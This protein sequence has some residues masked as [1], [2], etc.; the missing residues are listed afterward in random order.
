MKKIYKMSLLA[1]M[2]IL[3]IGCDREDF[4][5][6]NTNPSDV[7]E[8]DI[9]FLVAK[10]VELMYNNDYTVWFYNNFDYV[11]PW[12]Q[13]TG[14]G[15]GNGEEVVEMGPFGNQSLYPALMANARDVQFKVDEMEDRASMQAMRAMTIPSVIHT[16]LSV[17][18][19]MGY[20]P[21]TEAGLAAYTTPALLRPVY[22]SQETLFNT[23]L[24]EL[25][26]A[27][28]AFTSSDQTDI[29]EQ[30]VVF[31]GDYAKW[32]KF[33]NLLKLRIA[34]RLINKDR[35]KALQIAEQVANSSVGYMD[36]LA[37]DFIY[38]RDIN[39]FG[40][41]NGTQPGVGGK[42]L[43][44][45][46]VANKDPRV[47]FLFDK[48]DF[49]GEVVQTF[50]DNG[51]ALPAYVE[52]YV[53]YDVDGNFAGWTGPGEPW[54]RYFGAPLSPDKRF[55]SAY[56]EYFR[57]GEL[58]RITLSVDGN[59]YEKT[60]SSTSSYLEKNVRT[61]INYIYPTTVGPDARYIDQGVE[62]PPLNV[63]LGSSAE[64]NLYL[65]E[66]KLLGA[67]VPGDAQQYFNRGV[68]LSVQRMDALAANN[69]HPYYE[70]DPVYEDGAMA[71]AGATKLRAGEVTDLLSQPA[72]DL[73]TDG[74]EKVYI[75]QLINFAITPG[76]VFTLT[77][78]SGI[79]KTGSAYF[80]REALL[81]SGTELVIPRR[82][83][84]GT[85]TEDNANYE[86]YVNAIQEQGFSTGT[87][88]PSTLN[89]ERI[90]FDK[91]NPNYGVGP[92]N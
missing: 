46:L 19:N 45:F 13:I 41:G 44:D 34:A 6:L 36:N 74:L 2:M 16:Y 9:R 80:P 79:P 89:T 26:Q 84:I 69:D 5:D 87:N 27:I 71:E 85:P 64:A 63:L 17:S 12:S 86:N 28:V 52:Q 1:C 61:G 48:N 47:R 54:V 53:E 31:N 62:Y 14:E 49:N 11:Y 32:A 35:A 58:N 55:D 91:E 76:D 40:T 60:Y 23:W 68:E 24:Q 18:D 78:R 90:W 73:S 3:A 22:D 4:A 29:G 88:N 92:N 10:T 59:T 8:P 21:Y 72:Y 33:C 7:S 57:Q 30:D 20:L 70:A 51:K 67:N 25:D 82:F 50:I 38:R 15:V 43:V 56:D 37:D 66:F 83:T 65:A 75:Q 77:R 42:N 81:A 39:Y